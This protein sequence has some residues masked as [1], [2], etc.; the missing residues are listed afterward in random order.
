MNMKTVTRTI[1]ERTA[2]SLTAGALALLRQ[3]GRAALLLLLL[4]V[5]SATAWAQTSASYRAYNTSSHAFET[6]TANSCTAVTSGT[7]TMSNGWYVVSSNV[8]VSTRITVN[9]TVNLILADGYSLTASQGITV[10]S[11]NTLNIYGQ[12]SGTGAL[13]ATGAKLGGDGTEAAGIGSTGYSAVG[14]ITIHGG[15][16]T[17]TGADWS[18]GIGG[19]VHGGVGSVTIYG[20][21]TLATAGDPNYGSQ[22]AI[23]SG[24]EGSNVTKTLAD[25]LRVTTYNNT[26]PV[27]YGN[28]VSNL[29][30]KKVTVEPCTSHNLSN[31]VCTY[32]G[33][34][35]Y[36]VTYNGNN[37]TSGTVPA[38]PATYQSGTTVTVLGN[39]GSLARTGYT[40]SGWNTQANGSGTDYTAGATFAISGNTTLYAKWTPITYTV[41]FNKNHDD[42]TGTM[43]D[44]T[45]TYDAAQT[46]TANAFTRDGY[47]FVGWSTTTDGA[48]DYTDGQSVTNLANVQDAVVNLYARWATLYT[49]TYNLAG[50][51]VATPNP[52]TYSE[53]SAA[54]TLTN[55]T[56]DGYI[57]T[58]WT[59][60]GLSEPTMTVTIP[61]GST[62]NRSYT[63]TW[64]VEGTY[65]AYNTTTGKFE[66]RMIPDNITS[67]TSSTTTMGADNTV[68]WYTVDDNATVSSRI[69]VAGTVNLVL[70][71]DK[72]LTASQ[73]LHVPS[74]VTLNIYGQSGGTGALIATWSGNDK[75]GIGG[76]NNEGGGTIT[77]HGGNVTAS[78]GGYAAGIG[79]GVNGSGG[80]FTIR[81]GSVT[82]SSGYLGA[83][84]GARVSA[85]AMK[86]L[87]APSPLVV[88]RS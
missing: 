62:G 79:G 53:L 70:C 35:I 33:L 84:I 7:T 68:T 13:N 11:G 34:T 72:T 42:A 66:T 73:G 26:T 86:E 64:D 48:V 10:N 43:S 31:N 87:A 1:G 18:A 47:D 38:S 88:V 9:G 41:R 29:Q 28:R 67:V 77:I 44:Q 82:A 55:P 12:T 63:A 5:T 71:N 21:T 69:E 57:F 52:T 39:T 59:G 23:G 45:F 80:S 74:G 19:G 32:C 61:A 58:G 81:G 65:L 37:A 49:I 56:R 2:L 85:V 30:E 22:D 3:S 4:L 36:N 40:Y 83:G 54:I 51:A 27:A 16:I 78:S 75:A 8:T 20:G 76:D 6:L 17:A 24:S 14:S 15:R 46:L 60:T 50:G 25:G